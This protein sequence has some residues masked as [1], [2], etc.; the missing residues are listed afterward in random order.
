MNKRF[1][2]ILMEILCVLSFSLMGLNP[3]F[4]DEVTISGIVNENYEIIADDGTVYEVADTDMGNDLLNHV[5]KTVDV[6]GEVIDEGG[7]KVI[8]VKSYKILEKTE[9]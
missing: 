9:S 7:V 1:R 3:V 5:G 4:A 6:T 2:W 8:N